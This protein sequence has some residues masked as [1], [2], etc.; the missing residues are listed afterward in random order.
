MNSPNVE[1]ALVI[2]KY[3]RRKAKK[4]RAKLME[5]AAKVIRIAEKL[6]KERAERRKKRAAKKL[7]SSSTS[8][9]AD[10]DITDILTVYD[11]SLG[12]TLYYYINIL[13]VRCVIGSSK[14]SRASSFIKI[15]QRHSGGVFVLDVYF[16]CFLGACWV[17]C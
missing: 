9:T 13:L 6:A 8:S 17:L 11:P 10:A 15:F 2:G 16:C 4:A 3:P 7:N 5:K 1:T 12:F 14:S